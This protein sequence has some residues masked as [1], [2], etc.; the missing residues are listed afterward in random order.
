[1]QSEVRSYDG[2]LLC[3][4]CLGNCCDVMGLRRQQEVGNPT[5]NIDKRVRSKDA[6]YRNN[7][8][9]RRIKKVEVAQALSCRR[10]AVAPGD[11]DRIIELETGLAAALLVTALI[12]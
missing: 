2:R 6:R 7:K 3:Q 5:A 9:V 4:R 12:A 8:D 11:T 10:L 1:M